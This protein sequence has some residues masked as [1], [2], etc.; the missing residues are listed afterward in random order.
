MVCFLVLMGLFWIIFGA[1]IVDKQEAKF[2]IWGP[3]YY[4]QGRSAIFAG[5]GVIIG[6]AILLI[7]GVLSVS[8]SNFGAVAFL[9][10]IGWVLLTMFVSIIIRDNK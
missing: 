5:S 3:P 1:L 10:S 9:L 4:V 7:G 6:G 8:N 2:S